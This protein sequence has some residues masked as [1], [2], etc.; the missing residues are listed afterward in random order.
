[1]TFLALHFRRPE[2]STSRSRQRKLL[3]DNYNSFSSSRQFHWRN[4]ALFMLRWL[5]EHDDRLSEASFVLANFVFLPSCQT[6]RAPIGRLSKLRH[7][8]YVNDAMPK[9]SRDIVASES[10]ELRSWLKFHRLHTTGEG[11]RM[12][13]RLASIPF[14]SIERNGIKL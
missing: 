6:L 9:K 1:M 13:K 14:D 12:T 7:R 11:N 3:N 8:V 5:Y 10:I 4:A 2:L